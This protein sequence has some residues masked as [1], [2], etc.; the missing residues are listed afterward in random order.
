MAT[1]FYL[2]SS[3]A[4]AVTPAYSAAWDV[5]SSAVQLRTSPTKAS[6]TMTTISYLDNN[7]QDRDILAVQY[8]SDPIVAQLID[9]STVKFQIRASETS[10]ARNMFT[11]IR[12]RVCSNDGTT[13]TGGLLA[14]TRDDTEM[15][16]SL[17]NRQFS[18][19]ITAVTANE[20]DRIIIEIGGGGN[21]AL[22][23]DHDHNLRVGDEASS[24]LPED[25]TD[26]NDY[27]SW[28]Q[29]THDIT[30]QSAP[31]EVIQDIISNNSFWATPR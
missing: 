6:T 30:F 13:F 29:F 9:V 1:R 22:D 27:N 18:A 16:T 12:L 10:N 21:P 2:P 20:G 8:I 19:A 5:T 3:G 14:L 23:S 31:S 28:V 26:T 7:D 17:T 25:D 4:A 15:A 24:D 11:A